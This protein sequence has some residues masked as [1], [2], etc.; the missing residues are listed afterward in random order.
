M[1]GIVSTDNTVVELQIVRNEAIYRQNFY[2][3]ES[4]IIEG[5]QVMEDSTLTVPPSRPWIQVFATAPNMEN[6]SNWKDNADPPNWLPVSTTSNNMDNPT[7]PKRNNTRYA[8]VYI[9]KIGSKNMTNNT[10]LYAYYVYG[11]FD[12]T[13]G[14]GRSMIRMGYN[15]RF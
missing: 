10:S 13:S 6:I 4:A 12:S 7:I 5:G 11:L 2:K 15:K 1:I 14:Q 9:K 3:A 8:A